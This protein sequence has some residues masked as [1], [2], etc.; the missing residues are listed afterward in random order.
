MQSLDEEVIRVLDMLQ[1][2]AKDQPLAL[3]IDAGLEIMPLH[4]RIGALIG[5]VEPGEVETL[6][7]QHF[8]EEAL[9]AADLD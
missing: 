3:N 8:E 9:A 2:V 1:H 4:A 6:F 5:G 7:K